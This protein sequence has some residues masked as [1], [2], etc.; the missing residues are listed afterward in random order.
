MNIEVKNTTESA[1]IAHLIADKITNQ[2]SVGRHVT[3]LVAGGSCVPIAVEAAKLIDPSIQAKLVVSLTDERYGPVDHRDSN[4]Y[5]LQQAWFNLPHATLV[6][7][8]TGG[9]RTTTVAQFNAF[10]K[11]E[12]ACTDYAFGLFG[13]GVDGHTSGILPHSPAVESPAL[14]ATYDG[15]GYERITTTA[16]T[17]LRVSEAVIFA[18]GEAKWS[19][20]ATLLRTDA[21]TA[22]QPAQLLKQIQKS[23]LFTDYHL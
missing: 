17:I 7:V 9:D 21:P 12:L 22:D 15:G 1:V 14:V 10:L 2:L 23:T 20:L 19:A 11:T 5:Q 13:I 6:P 16:H 18:A 8:L 3:W 4:W